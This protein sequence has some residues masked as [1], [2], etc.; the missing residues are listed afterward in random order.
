MLNNDAGRIRAL[1]ALLPRSALGRCTAPDQRAR[2]ALEV[3][4]HP[5]QRAREIAQLGNQLAH[6][7]QPFAGETLEVR[8]GA[9]EDFLTEA[10]I[11]YTSRTL[12]GDIAQSIVEHGDAAQ[13][14]TI[15]MGTR[16]MGALPNLVM[17][18]IA[19]KV[20]HL[21]LVPVVLVH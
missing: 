3:G 15:Y 20:V 14:R 7:G 5:A 16:G 13:C 19:T 4:A 8:A 18:S 10:G 1:M 21:A 6:F 11:A 9:V 12:V 2:I 17:G